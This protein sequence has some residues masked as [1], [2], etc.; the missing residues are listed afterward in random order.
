MGRSPRPARSPARAG[1]PRG[2][3]TSSIQRREAVAGAGRGPTH[4]AGAPPRGSPPANR[5]ALGDLAEQPAARRLDAP[6]GR[7]SRRPVG[8]AGCTPPAAA[9]VA[10]VFTRSASA[11]P[12]A[13][14]PPRWQ[15]PRSSSTSPARTAHRGA[16]VTR[17]GRACRLAT[18]PRAP[19]RPVALDFEALD[20]CWPVGDALL[21]R[22]RRR[23][24]G[25]RPV[26]R[27]RCSR[28]AVTP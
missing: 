10:S 17:D 11:T 13:S 4:R 2:L 1:R 25:P 18:D 26:A 12:S 22:R 8:R 16:G 27:D 24:R 23:Q 21:S 5:L 19:T 15:G 20:R 7:P 9:H 6:A 3:S 28:L 14:G